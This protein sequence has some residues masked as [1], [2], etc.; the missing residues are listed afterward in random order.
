MRIKFV[1]P[2]NFD[3]RLI[4]VLGVGMVAQTLY[5]MFAPLSGDW[6]DWYLIGV[7]VYWR[8]GQIFGIYTIPPY[9][10]AA[11]YALWLRLPISHPDPGSIV[12]FPPWGLPPYFQPTPAALIFVLMMKLP[13]LIS[14]AV[15]AVLIYK[16]LSDSGASRNRIYFCGFR[17]AIEPAHIGARQSE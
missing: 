8:P 6:R 13:A 17:V 14:D 1:I 16:I 5:A 9:I 10:F 4:L 11:F 12:T 3:L 2:R 7:S 15:I